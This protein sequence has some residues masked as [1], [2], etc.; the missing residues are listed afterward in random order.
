VIAV[1]IGAMAAK[2]PPVPEGDFSLWICCG[3][4]EE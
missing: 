3:N 1:I 2:E 4:E